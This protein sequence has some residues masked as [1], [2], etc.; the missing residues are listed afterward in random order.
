MSWR[1]ALAAVVLWATVVCAATP[2][3][4]GDDDARRIDQGET[5]VHQRDVDG[6]AWPEVVVYRR[7]SAAP[8]ALMALFADF[9]GQA[10]WVPA[11]VESRVV[12]RESSN[13]FRVF[14]EYEVIGP[15][16]RYTVIITLTRERDVWVAQWTLV[17]AR[18]AR[19]IE[20]SLR[21]APRAGGSLVTYTQVVDPG[22]LGATFGSP[23]TLAAKVVATA[24][25]LTA[26]TE[27]LAASEPQQLA[28]L[29]ATLTALVAP[30]R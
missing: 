30:A 10:S 12:G 28:T 7:S 14:Y 5:V 2:T 21:I 20:G 19:R 18:Y 3:P 29:V 11:V 17:S 24:E 8:V 9:A 23:A 22:T 15:N 25:A 27:R 4:L 16:E 26:R 13:A 1:A 6:F